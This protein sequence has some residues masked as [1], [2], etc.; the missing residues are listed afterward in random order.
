MSRIT[1]L[2]GLV[3]ALPPVA[4]ERAARLYQV[5]VVTGRTDP[6]P[7]LHAWLEHQFGSVEAVRDQQVTRVVNRWTQ[8]GALFSP[9]RARRPQEGGSNGQAEDAYRDGEGS[10]PFCHPETG[11]PADTFGRI[12]SAHAVTGAN[13]AKYDGQ[14]GIIVFR[15]HHP[16]AFDEETVVDLLDIGRRWADA[17]RRA[18]PRAVAYLL[19]WNA[20]PRA[21]GSIIHGH[22][23]VMLGRPPHYPQ[24]ER[25][26]RDAHRYRAETGANYLQ[27]LVA[28]HRDLGLL[29]AEAGG[30][31]TIA[32]LTPVKERELLIIGPAGMDERHPAFAGAV[33]RTV[34]AYRDVLGVRAFNLALHR[35]PLTHGRPTTPPGWEN[36]G[37]VVHLVDRGDPR[38]P[39]SDIGAMELYAA[40]V[41]GGD[42]F[43]L[44]ARLRSALA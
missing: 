43:E 6:P 32:S 44:A 11:T 36:I 18:D 33:A 15:R 21:G 35:P 16:L 41:V 25:L 27:D 12:E 34:V 20:G 30:V 19:I 2:P 24:V 42:P 31:A 7:E 38:S 8:D 17:A 9:L 13:A 5:E 22:A 39:S 29:I 3:A 26:R 10:D 4:R 28:V 14:H 23:Q 1:Q 40:S 37:P